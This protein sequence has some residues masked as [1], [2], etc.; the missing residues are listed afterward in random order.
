MQ[1]CGLVLQA[2]TCLKWLGPMLQIIRI[3]L[4]QWGNFIGEFYSLYMSKKV[5]PYFIL[6]LIFLILAIHILANIYSWY[7]QFEWLDMVAHTLG[8]LFIASFALYI[9]Y[10]SGYISSI[11]KTFSFILFLS[12]SSV[13]IAGYLWEVFEYLIDE[14]VSLYENPMFQ[15]G[16]G[17]MLSDFSFD[18]I[19]GI[20]AAFLFK[21]IWIKV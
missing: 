17:D 12:I 11:H 2:P 8:G 16:V 4:P 7:W 20:L 5:F 18:I 10:N 15:L 13:L 6:I 3:K 14:H 1:D 21:Y 19:G 9:Y